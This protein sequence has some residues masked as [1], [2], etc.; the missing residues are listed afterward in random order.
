MFACGHKV[1]SFEVILENKAF[2]D[3][4]SLFSDI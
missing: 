3:A 1:S 2:F 4:Q